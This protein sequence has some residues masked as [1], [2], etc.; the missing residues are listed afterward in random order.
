MAEARKACLHQAFRASFTLAASLYIRPADPAL[1]GDLPLGMRSLAAQPIAQ[2]D[3]LSL[4]G[5]QAGLDALPHFFT[6]VPGVQFFQHIV[7][8]RDYVHQ[9]ERVP[10][11][12]RLQRLGERDLSLQLL[13]GPKMHQDL[14][15]NTPAG[16]GGQP[17][18]FV[19]L[20]G[21]DPLDEADGANGDQVVLVPGLGVVFF[22]RVKQKE[23]FSRSKTT[24]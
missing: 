7:I 21:G 16:I 11:A 12:S 8:H 4:P 20:K 9:G 10:V 1:G 18:V 3:D 2:G 22:G 17:D 19:R 14:I 13:L 24:P 5:R 23:E 6:G 15:F